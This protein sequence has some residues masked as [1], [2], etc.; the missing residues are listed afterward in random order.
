MNT[1]FIQNI[2]I[3][4]DRISPYSYL[5]NIRA[6][7]FEGRLEFQKNITFFVGKMDL[8]NQPFLR[9]LP[10]HMGLIRKGAAGIIIFLPTILIR[11]F[12]RH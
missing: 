12:I 9:G 8:G 4:W 6:L 10:W 7:Q 1:R 3:D 11:N 2:M 5:K